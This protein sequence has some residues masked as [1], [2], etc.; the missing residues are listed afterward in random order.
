[1]AENP[2]LGKSSQR[3]HMSRSVIV[4]VGGQFLSQIGNVALIVAAYWYASSRFGAASLGFLGLAAGL[5]GMISLL[6]G[7]FI[8][9]WNSRHAMIAVDLLRALIMAALTVLILRHQLSL[10]RLTIGL[11]LLE[12]IGSLF[13]PAEMRLI[14]TLVQ[15]DQLPSV[16]AVNRAAMS[17]AQVIS[18]GVSGALLAV[19]G[20]AGLFLTNAL[21]FVTSA[22][23]LMALQVGGAE[24]K[25]PGA[26]QAPFRSG[27]LRRAFCAVLEALR[28]K[29][30][31]TAEKEFSPN[32]PRRDAVLWAGIDRDPQN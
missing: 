12:A 15:R 23:S 25:E 28:D 11:F 26:Q 7:P 9:R 5:G 2:N 21:S 13:S 8:D 32:N 16:N 27:N 3:F 18:W 1:M 22:I 29:G 19:I 10:V 24:R 4:L 6:S 20:V 31:R 30:L 17:L 14:P